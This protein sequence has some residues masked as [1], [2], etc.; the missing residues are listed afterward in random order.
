[1]LS[2]SFGLC[3]LAASL[4]VLIAQGC[5]KKPEGY[6]RLSD[7]SVNY[8]NWNCKELADEADLL[9][10]SLAVAIEQ[11]SAEH[12]AHLKAETLAVQRAKAS[13]NCRA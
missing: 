13:K 8:Q 1:V 3:S 11:R 7:L 6:P 5:T 2:R 12:V 9:E 10:D 4:A